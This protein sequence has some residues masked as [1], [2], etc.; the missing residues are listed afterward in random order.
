MD[1]SSTILEVG[2]KVRP[3]VG[4]I[5][6]QFIIDKIYAKVTSNTGR[7]AVHK[8]KTEP[9]KKFKPNKFKRGI[10]LVGDIESATGLGQ[11]IRLLA[12]VMEDQNIPFATH[13]FT[14]NENGF[15]QEN[16][17]A[18]KNTKGYPYGINVFHINT[19]DFPSAYLKLGPKPWSEHYNIA[20]WVW[21]LEELPEHWIPYM[22]MANEFWTPSEF[23]SS[24]FRKYTKK[25]VVTVPHSVTASYDEK[26]DR[27][28]FGLPEDKFLFLTM[29]A[30]DSL[31]ERKNPQA[32]V[33]AFK[34]AFKKNDPSVGLVIKVVPSK[35]R[36]GDIDELKR[37]TAGYNNVYFL[38]GEYEKIEV[39]SMLRDVDAYVSLHRSEGFGLTLAESMMLGTPTISTNW[40]GNVE[41]QNEDTA[42]MVDY[43]LVD[44]GKNI[45]LFPEGSKW[46]EA[47]ANHAAEYMKKL[48]SDKEFYNRIKE[49]GLKS[50]NEQLSK[51]S[52]GKIVNKRI[53]AIY[54]KALK[55][56]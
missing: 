42:C 26:Y 38:T 27:K 48:Y 54:N 47:S 31:V 55:N 19:A 1:L 50:I 4:K 44:V 52:V 24:V 29:Y 14:L 28:Y 39:N 25:K 51:E 6:P 8:F 49:N 17:F 43:K 56:Q 15:S 12:G 46:A 10:N 16:P 13:Q 5:V 36:T 41:F 22:C 40:S 23:A 35:H 32:V 11:S 20:H 9:K 7:M 37:M 53:N 33:R 34:K 45:P 21:E 3:V 18:D 2:H 30:S